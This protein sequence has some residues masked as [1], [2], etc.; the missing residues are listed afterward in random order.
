MRSASILLAICLASTVSA[1]SFV[2]AYMSRTNDAVQFLRGFSK[3]LTGED[4]G[5]DFGQC[6]SEG[7]DLVTML[8]NAVDTI[9]KGGLENIVSGIFQFVH[10]ADNLPTVF[11]DCKTISQSALAKLKVFASR[12]SDLNTLF[13]KV[14]MNMLFHGS[15]ILKDFGNAKTYIDNADFFDGGLF[16][17]L[18]INVATQ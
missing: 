18:A 1:Y 17:G 3:G 2:D 5:E 7:S 16:G 11:S 15:E 9:E 12:F 4:L 14:S 6:I 13:H 8:E 10:V